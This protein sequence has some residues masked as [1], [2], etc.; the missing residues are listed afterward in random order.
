MYIFVENLAKLYQTTNNV[1]FK[2]NF[3]KWKLAQDYL[4]TKSFIY[5][6][7]NY[8]H[9]GSNHIKLLPQTLHPIVQ[10]IDLFKVYVHVALNYIFDNCKFSSKYY[11]SF[12]F[13]DI[14]L[15]ALTTLSLSIDVNIINNPL[16][17]CWP[18][19]LKF[20][21]FM[22]NKNVQIRLKF[23]TIHFLNCFGEL[24]ECV[25]EPY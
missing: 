13:R 17:K 19:G 1:F 6:I 4:A 18:I 3:S 5:S 20:F 23:L 10:K 2:T 12:Y 22:W 11:S 7:I 14:F 16:I 24:T 15:F 25:C 8:C 21:T 9:T